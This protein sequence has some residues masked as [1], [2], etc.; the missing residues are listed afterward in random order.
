MVAINGREASNL[1]QLKKTMPRMLHPC[2]ALTILLCACCTAALIY[3]FISEQ[4]ETIA[5]YFVYMLSVYILIVIAINAP[6][7]TNKIKKFIY[8]NRLGNRYMTELS[9]RAKVSL[10]ISFL[11]NLSYAVFKLLAGIHYASFWFGIDAV[12]YIILSAARFLLLR[13]LRQDKRDLAK[14]FK[15]YRFCGVLLVVLNAALIGVVYQII[16]NNMR[17]E[18]PGILIY[19]VAA[20]TFYCITVSIINV[21]KYRKLNS[22]VLSAQKAISL[23]K[24]LVAMFALQTAMFASFNEDIALERIM[25][26]VSGSCVCFAIFFLAVWMVIRANR[27]L[28]NRR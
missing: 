18:Y 1:E 7:M 5:A 4:Q 9:Y 19:V 23:A 25:N 28:K 17:Y 21:V 22:P 27:E 16:H 14:E 15:K 2:L 20:Y 8:Q 26:L 11:F 3:I 13:H 10:Y 6:K 12:Y 24:S